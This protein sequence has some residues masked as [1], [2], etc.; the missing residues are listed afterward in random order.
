[1]VEIENLAIKRLATKDL[2]RFSFP[3]EEGD[4]ETILSIKIY[5]Q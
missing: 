5:T 4:L 3:L 1:L 2:V